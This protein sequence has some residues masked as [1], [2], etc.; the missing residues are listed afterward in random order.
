MRDLPPLRTLPVFLSVCR[1][2]NFT[3]AAEELYITHSAVSQNI[4]NLESFLGKKL[5]KRTTRTMSLTAEGERYRH[6]IEEGMNIIALATQRELQADNQVCINAIPT[7]ALKW[8]IPR[9][10]AFTKAFPDIELK[11]SAI[12]IADFDIE[13]DNLDIAIGYGTSPDWW[14]D[15]VAKQWCQDQL[16]LVG[17]PALLEKY[18]SIEEILANETQIWI[19]NRYRASDWKQ[20][21]TAKQ[22]PLPDDQKKQ[23]FESSTQA[24]QAA[25]AGVGIFVT[26]GIFVLDEIASGQL[27]ELASPAVDID[28][29]YYLVYQPEKLVNDN[30]Q[31]VVQWLMEQVE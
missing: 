5:I 4:H 26:H 6:S 1:H 2:L 16:L 3:K 20:W 11:L 29:Y 28:S 9:L 22:L 21:T 30:V 18:G 24:I 12:S 8:L 31:T 27:A 15:S 10:P 7:L 13:S 19:S 17:Q 23:F 14:P 25:I